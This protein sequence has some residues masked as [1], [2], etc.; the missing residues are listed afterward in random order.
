MPKKWHGITINEDRF[1]EDFQE[2]SKIGKVGE[3]GINRTA[4]S[5]A[6]MEARTWFRSKIEL[7]GL[8]FRQDEAGNHSG[9]LNCGPQNAPVLL[10]G[11]HLDSVPNG[12][13]FD[14]ALGVLA[15]LEVLRTVKD[16]GLYL[17]VNLE[18]IDFTDEEGSLVNFFGSFALAGL[19]E[20]EHLNNPR[21]G[22]KPLQEGLKRAGL[23][24]EKILSSKRDLAYLAGYLELHIEQGQQLIEAGKKIGIVSSIAGLSFYRLTFIGRAD[25]AGTT[26]IESRKDAG[27]GGSYFN[28][29]L[30]E[31]IIDRFPECFANVGIIQL[32]PGAFN[33][34]PEKAVLSLEFRSPEIPQ[35]H[36]LKEDVMGL[37]DEAAERYH[38]KL[39]VEFLG[40]R[41]PVEM[42][43]TAQEAVMKA[44]DELGLP[45]MPLN[46]RAGHDAQ[47]LA[48]VCPTGMIFVP[49]EAGI[50]HSPLEFTT[51]DDCVNGA[52]VLL[53]SA[54]NM[55]ESQ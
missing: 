16:K 44:A 7:A 35:F 46:S 18:V 12:G 21:G 51:W 32:Q 45:A 53:I 42:S 28:L 23:K 55:A 25:H 48:L 17:P 3:S 40:E 52:N 29:S 38:L 15:G 20:P 9:F 26:P 36:I 14:G 2:L 5:I 24:P 41:E 33:I 47:A 49:S 22:R 54:L 1:R 27:L 11:S 8:D 10:L 39:E 37:A 19:L 4:F 31:M 6:H 13:R 34:V 50:S 30:R 43:R